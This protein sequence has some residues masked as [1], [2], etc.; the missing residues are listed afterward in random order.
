[1]LWKNYEGL[2]CASAPTQEL[3][4]ERV[5]I[6]PRLLTPG[7]QACLRTLRR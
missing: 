4:I 6:P 1:M 7:P 5:K 3:R 2:Q